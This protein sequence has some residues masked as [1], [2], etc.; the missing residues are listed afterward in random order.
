MAVED[1]FDKLKNLPP[2]LVARL[3]ADRDRA[4]AEHEQRNEEHARKFYLRGLVQGIYRTPG[5][6]IDPNSEIT[7]ICQ[8]QNGSGDTVYT[9]TVRTKQAPTEV[10]PSPDQIR[11]LSERIKTQQANFGSLDPSEQSRIRTDSSGGRTDTRFGDYL[12]NEALA[13]QFQKLK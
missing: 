7:A 13:A 11:V 4:R 9:R 5:G 2:E 8:W 6:L 12:A 3:K 10:L 1:P